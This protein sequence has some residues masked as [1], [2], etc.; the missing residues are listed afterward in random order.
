MQERANL[1]APWDECKQMNRI[2][3]HREIFSAGLMGLLPSGGTE[4]EKARRKTPGFF[5]ES[6]PH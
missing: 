6:L 5:I 3:E 2:I 1:S 4:K